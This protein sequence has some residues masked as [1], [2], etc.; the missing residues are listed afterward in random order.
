MVEQIGVSG[1]S[2]EA[3]GPNQNIGGKQCSMDSSRATND[4]L[5][6][7]GMRED[8]VRVLE[9]TLVVG[10]PP[11]GP[12]PEAINLSDGTKTDLLRPRLF[13]SHWQSHPCE[14]GWEISIRGRES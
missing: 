14:H 11:E 2:E 8:R 4:A 6:V 5:V 7:A 13:S 1:V 10:V 9:T 12:P 3:E